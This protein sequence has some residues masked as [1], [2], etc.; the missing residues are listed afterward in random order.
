MSEP[1]VA[2][3]NDGNPIWLDSIRFLPGYEA[4]AAMHIDPDIDLIASTDHLASHLL[5]NLVLQSGAVVT[6]RQDSRQ[7][8]PAVVEVLKSPFAVLGSAAK[9]GQVVLRADGTT[10]PDTR[11]L[12]SSARA[13]AIRNQKSI[14]LLVSTVLPSAIPGIL[15]VGQAELHLIPGISAEFAYTPEIYAVRYRDWSVV[16]FVTKLTYELAS[17]NPRDDHSRDEAFTRLRTVMRESRGL[18]APS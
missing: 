15:R 5:V 16:S 2:E 12:R 14:G 10:E 9:R 4:Q 6:D 17:F 7:A 18:A 1:L 8:Q 11:M 3:F 13:F